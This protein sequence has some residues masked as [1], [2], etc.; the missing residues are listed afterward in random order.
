M[1]ENKMSIVVSVVIFLAVIAILVFFTVNGD[2]ESKVATVPN[3]WQTEGV[4]ITMQREGMGG[5]AASV[6]D[7][8]A[9]NYTGRLADGTVFDSNVDPKFGHVQPFVLTI[10]SGEVIKGWD[11]GIAG[12]KLGEKRALEISPEYA[13]GASGAGKAIPPNAT[14]TFEVELL[15]IK[16]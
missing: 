16:K 7:T 8:V 13:Y 12:M 2:R 1:K 9:V 6:G 3:T 5:A 11:V 14:I 4:K 10:G 15:Q